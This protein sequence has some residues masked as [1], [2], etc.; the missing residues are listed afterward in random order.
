MLAIA[1]LLIAVVGACGSTTA[2]SVASTTTTEAVTTTTTTQPTTTTTAPTTTTVP[3]KALNIEIKVFDFWETETSNAYNATTSLDQGAECIADFVT[4]K[5]AIM[6]DANSGDV[7]G[8]ERL[9]PGFLHLNHPLPTAATS[10]AQKRLFWS[11]DFRTEIDNIP[12][13]RDF[14]ILEIESKNDGGLTYGQA[15]I[16]RRT[17]ISMNYSNR[18]RD[19]ER[20][21]LE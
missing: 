9:E 1:G 11:C 14:Y 6:R 21:F 18:D 7:L 10:D 15:D 5:R 3:T 12:M 16:W 8:I 4:G 2:E 13:D 20:T 19:K 17:W